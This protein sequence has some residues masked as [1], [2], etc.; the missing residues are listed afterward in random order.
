MWSRDGS[1]LATAAWDLTS[2]VF[3]VRP[4]DVGVKEMVR[5]RKDIVCI[6]WN[7]DLSFVVTGG[8]D[9]RLLVF[10]GIASTG[11]IHRCP[12]VV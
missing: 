9:N 11:T 6:G 12:A 7:S 10:R 5:H 3:D 1:Q 2:R 4:V 8:Y